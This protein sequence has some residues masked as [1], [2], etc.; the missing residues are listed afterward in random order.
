[1][2]R[3]LIQPTRSRRQATKLRRKRAARRKLHK[4]FD[5]PNPGGRH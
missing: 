3:V 2:S 5:L 1:M 4:T